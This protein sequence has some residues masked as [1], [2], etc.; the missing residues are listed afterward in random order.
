MKYKKI[1]FPSVFVVILLT[2]GFL[3][4]KSSQ[5]DYDL[6]KISV[7]FQIPK[8]YSNI[9]TDSSNKLYFHN[10][11]NNKNYYASNVP[12]YSIDEFLIEPSGTEKGCVFDFKAPEFNGLI[13]YGLIREEGVDFRLPV[14]F[15]R[16]AEIIDGKAMINISHLRGKYD[17]VDWEKNKELLLGY[18]I[19][20]KNGEIIYDGKIRLKGNGPFVPGLTIIEGPFLNIDEPAGIII[21][22]TTNFQI[23]AEII[24]DKKKY[25]DKEKCTKHEIKIS[26][27]KPDTE[28]KY[29][30]TAGDYSGDFKFRTPPETGSRKPFT[31]AYAS[32]SRAGMGGG[33]RNIYGCNAYIS[34]KM[35]ALAVYKNASF[36]Q[37]TGD[38][39]DGYATDKN[40]NLLQYAN[41]KRA[42]EPF[43]HRIPFVI[44]MGNHEALTYT[45]L[46]NDEYIAGI[47][48]FPF[49]TESAEFTF[50]QV[51]VNPLNGPD[52]EDGS[53]YDPNP[54]TIDFPSYK[55]NV[56]FYTFGNVAMVVLNSNYWYAPNAELVKY[57]SGNIHAYIMDN[58]FEWLKETI[59]QLEN[60]DRIDH[61]F[62]T[63]HTPAFPNGGHSHDDMWYDGNN[64][65]RPYVAGKPVEKGIIERRDEILDILIN[66]S[67]K[68]VAILC[69]DE[70]NYSRLRLTNEIPIY[71]ENYKYPKIKIS[72][73][74]WQITNGAAGAPYYAQ[75]TLPWSSFVEKFTTQ[76]ALVFFHVEGKKIKI[77][78]LNPDTLELIEE[79]EMRNEN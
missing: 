52:S 40:Y 62:V 37:F 34:K 65:F 71:P 35:A 41:W 12:E 3:L 16:T 43:A 5:G 44:G 42:I 21:S 76:Y 13:Y 57:T 25:K 46:E 23:K 20:N 38:M 33:E 17:F 68:T 18:R 22:F 73:T 9:K 24:I 2:T 11:A 75:E 10:P 56:F 14:F 50:S 69:G 79:F 32:D 51:V 45:F 48:K 64:N 29:T 49:D 27:L 53:K 63:L 7:D 8:S 60:D 1:I 74:F 67:K 31:F 19:V 6:Q 54:E 70:H 30:L 58:Q 39:I 78:V 15:K 66:K 77:E 26:N 4:R 61:I 72:R 55:E 47:D 36:L 28:Y 59:A